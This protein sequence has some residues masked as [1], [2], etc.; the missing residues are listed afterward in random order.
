MNAWDAGNNQ[1]NKDEPKWIRAI[2]NLMVDDTHTWALPYLEKIGT[3]NPPF[4][5]SWTD[6]KT[7]FEKRF[8]H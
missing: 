1:W 5:G 7:A 3:I 8:M 2:L 4:A 6:F